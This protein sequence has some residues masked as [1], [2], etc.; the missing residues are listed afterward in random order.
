MHGDGPSQFERILD[1]SAQDF[2]F[3]FIGLL[4][5]G[6]AFVVPDAWLHRDNFPRAQTY[7]YRLV[8]LVE[9]GY[10]A[11]CAIDPSTVF[12][13]GDEYDLRILFERKLFLRWQRRRGEVAFY[14]AVQGDGITLQPVQLP[15]V[16]I[17][18]VPAFGGE[19]DDR[20]VFRWFVMA[21]DAFIDVPKVL[22]GQPA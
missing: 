22:I 2:L 3:H 4:I 7:V 12:V 14:S 11:Q 16:D 8:L 13:V 15:L 17:A 5:I 20:L 10:Y 19:G 1:E 21:I 6:E 18:H 9:T